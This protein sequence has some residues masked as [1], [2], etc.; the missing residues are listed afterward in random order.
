MKRTFKIP[1]TFPGTFNMDTVVQVIIQVHSL[2][3]GNRVYG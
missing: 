2:K 1:G 3:K